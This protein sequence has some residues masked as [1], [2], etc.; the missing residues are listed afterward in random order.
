MH[1]WL[2]AAWE[3][4]T[5]KRDLHEDSE[6]AA[7]GNYWAAQSYSA[8]ERGI[9]V[10][11]GSVQALTRPVTL[12]AVDR[13]RSGIA[14]TRLRPL[15]RCMSRVMAHR[16]SRLTEGIGP[17]RLSPAQLGAAPARLY[18]NRHRPI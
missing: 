2:V 1:R 13:W 7:V 8:T 12:N 5:T 18:M 9:N 3:G 16:V 6:W 10:P 4:W 14:A 11:H 17:L 15:L